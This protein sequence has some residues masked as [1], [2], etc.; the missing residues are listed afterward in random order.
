MYNPVAIRLVTQKVCPKLFQSG[1]RQIQNAPNTNVITVSP[2]ISRGK[3][4][5]RI[6]QMS[7]HSSTTPSHSNELS[8]FPRR[9]FVPRTTVTIKL[10]TN[11]PTASSNARVNIA[12]RPELDQ[13]LWE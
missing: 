5:V 12:Y 9:T 11:H 8:Q 13:P 10:M 1:S 7:P 2:I 6:A 3:P 4:N